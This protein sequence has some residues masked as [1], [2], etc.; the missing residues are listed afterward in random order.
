MR[1]SINSPS[2]RPWVGLPML[3]VVVASLGLAGCNDGTF[4]VQT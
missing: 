4:D 3:Y 2:L 1:A